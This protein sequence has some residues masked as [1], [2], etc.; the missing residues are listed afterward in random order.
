MARGA[1][2]AAL[3]I[4]AEAAWCLAAPVQAG[5]PGIRVYTWTDA[6]GVTHF[7]DT[8]RHEGPTRTLKLP[9]PPPPDR[10]AL[11]ADRAW[12]RKMD[13]E[14]QAE[15]ARQAARRRA[16]EETPAPR[17]Q[18]VAQ[19]ERAA[20][21]LP[22]YFPRRHFRRHHRHGRGASHLPS[23]A[24]PASALPSSFPDPLAS[25]FPPGLPSSFP[26]EQPPPGGG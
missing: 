26:E 7:S 12:Q 19:E 22:V 6:R 17:P 9:T 1:R 14:V 11:A 4:A 8:P 13:R 24:F 21:F 25:S 15:V 2:L 16:R 5:D 23:A 20:P 18:T 3:V 10:T